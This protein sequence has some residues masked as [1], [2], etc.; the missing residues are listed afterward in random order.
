MP[1]GTAQGGEVA[2]DLVHPSTMDG[3][4]IAETIAENGKA[5]VYVDH[6]LLRWP[7]LS[8]WSRIEWDV[9]L[10]GNFARLRISVDGVSAGDFP[11]SGTIK[12]DFAA[13]AIGVAYVTPANGGWTARYDNVAIDITPL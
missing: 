3:A 10:D 7:V 9:N 8:A 5:L 2:L 6:P 4:R 13:C 12:R 1:L 11:L